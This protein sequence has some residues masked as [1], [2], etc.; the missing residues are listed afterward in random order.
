M[1]GRWI[2]SPSDHVSKGRTDP[3]NTL[4][5]P[6]ESHP[7]WHRVQAKFWG[8]WKVSKTSTSPSIVRWGCRFFFLEHQRISKLKSLLLGSSGRGLCEQ[9]GSGKK[10]G[11]QSRKQPQRAS[12]ASCHRQP[13]FKA[14]LLCF[15]WHTYIVS[16]QWEETRCHPPLLIPGTQRITHA[17]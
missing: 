11:W 2:C 5:W 12:M 7:L 14:V 3:C 8:L 10:H 6:R 4:W 1:P 17:K 15:S 13:G 9:G 16:G